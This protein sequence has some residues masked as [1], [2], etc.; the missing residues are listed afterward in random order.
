MF[1]PAASGRGKADPPHLLRC[2]VPSVWTSGPGSTVMADGYV[3]V[4]GFSSLLSDA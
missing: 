3:P 1:T 2:W 4:M